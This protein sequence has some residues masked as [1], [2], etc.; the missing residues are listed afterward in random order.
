MSN[1][2]R[3]VFV[4]VTID[5][6]CDK[7]IGW[8]TQFPL[9]FTSVLRG[10]PDH[11]SPL[12]QRHG[13]RPTY[14]LSPEVMQDDDCAAMLASLPDAELGTHLHGEFLEPESDPQAEVTAMPQ[15]AYAS[16]VEA[17]KLENLTR[18][19]QDRFGR[20]PVSYRSGRFALSETTLPVLE[21]LGYSVDSSVTPFRTNRY[22]KGP[23][24]NYWGAPVHAYHPAPREPRKPGRSALVE[25]P[26]SLFN[27]YL[28]GFPAIFLRRLSDRWVK[29]R[30]VR[31]WLRGRSEIEWL[32]PGRGDAE[33]LCR[34]AD[35]LI[36]R[37]PAGR[38]VF[39]NLMFHNVD[40]MPGCS[41][42]VR[43]DDGRTAF[44]GS[45]EQLFT[46]LRAGYSMQPITLGE[47]PERLL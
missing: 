21:R 47:A 33:A 10:V 1:E 40:L 11:L 18:L 24:C 16:E 38:P 15:N 26:V 9:K 45:L 42:Y 22:E 41:P 25:V 28:M 46:H 44:L 2:R 37:W 29:T 31:R 20:R 13:I 27:E 4:L 36:R 3:E 34:S 43:D 39:L 32:R 14:L 8:K 35:R 7:G 6:E 17:A 23:A 30:L 19:F 12:F 5:T